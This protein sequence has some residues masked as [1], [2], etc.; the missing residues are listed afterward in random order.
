MSK[1]QQLYQQIIRQKI[2]TAE[3][4]IQRVATSDPN[5]AD[6]LRQE[7]KTLQASLGKVEVGAAS[8]SD[9]PALE[10]PALQRERPVFYCTAAD[11]AT[12]LKPYWVAL[13]ADQASIRCVLIQVFFPEDRGTVEF[14]VDQGRKLVIGKLSGLASTSPQA[15]L[16]RA[17]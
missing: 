14:G 6:R 15:E 8:L 11:A 13:C 12:K 3:Q 2:Q 5:L 10:M 17:K 16:L 9:G 4:Q 1:D 7:V